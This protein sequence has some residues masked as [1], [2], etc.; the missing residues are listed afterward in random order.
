MDG[1]AD[2]V[3]LSFVVMHNELLKH[4]RG[5][6]ILVLSALI[7]LILAAI[8]A[9]V[10]FL[11]DGLGDD[12]VGLSSLYCM[13]ISLMIIISVTL[14]GATTIVSEYEERTALILFTRPIRKWSIF[15]GKFMAAFA[16][17]TAFV[18]VYYLV[19]AVLCL[20]GPGKIDGTLWVSLGYAV[21]YCFATT[22]VAVLISCFMKKASTSSILTFFTLALFLDIVVAVVILA[23][24]LD[25][26]WYMINSA[27]NAITSV[28][29]ND[30]LGPGDPVDGPRTVM[31]LLLWGFV[32]AI[33]GYLGFSRRDF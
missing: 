25:D 5:R 26:P 7:G 12:P 6:R 23:A 24:G 28:F 31:V 21:C 27:G 33:L 20:I 13:V 2:D 22:G 29:G 4:V 8:T 17:T 15:T 10:V 18:I 9:A 19:V 16:I 32:P 14:F 3:R 11:G 1:F 30:L